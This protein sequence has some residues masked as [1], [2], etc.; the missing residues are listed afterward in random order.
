MPQVMAGRLAGKRGSDLLLDD[1]LLR[2][3]DVDE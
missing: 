1:I 2:H 3:A